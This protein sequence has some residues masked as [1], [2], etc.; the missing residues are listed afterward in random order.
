MFIFYREELGPT[1]QRLLSGQAGTGERD[2]GQRVPAPALSS[3]FWLFLPVDRGQDSASVSL[4][5]FL[6]KMRGTVGIGTLCG[7]DGETARCLQIVKPYPF[8]KRKKNHTQK[9][10]AQPLSPGQGAVA[11]GCVSQYVGGFPH[12]PPQPLIHTHT[13][14]L[15]GKKRTLYL[16]QTLHVAQLISSFGTGLKGLLNSN[17]NPANI[18]RVQSAPG[19]GVT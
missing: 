9:T 4:R 1:R 2:G 14:D 7:P 10:I 19:C 16:S 6:C 15:E 8:S 13:C 12:G 3:W 5:S 11:G 18:C 17:G